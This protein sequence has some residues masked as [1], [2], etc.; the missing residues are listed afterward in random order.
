MSA[1]TTWKI[2]SLTRRRPR[3]NRR[4]QGLATFPRLRNPRSEVR[5]RRVLSCRQD[6]N[7]HLAEKQSQGVE[8]PESRRCVEVT[9]E[10]ERMASA[11]PARN[12]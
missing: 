10:A 4:S 8:M 5:P 6:D 9:Q 1:P 7:L 11:D 12:E 3:H 2:D